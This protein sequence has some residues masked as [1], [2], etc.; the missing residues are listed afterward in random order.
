MH[1]TEEPWIMLLRVLIA[2]G[3]GAALGAERGIRGRAAGLRTHFLV[4]A[5]SALFMI[6]STHIGTFGPEVLAGFTRVTDPG[7]IAAQI[8]TGIGF[9]GAGAIIKEGF[10]VR[11]LTTAA[12]LWVSA[13]IGMA[14]GAGFYILAVGTTILALF[15]L[16]GIS[17]LERGIRRSIYRDLI[18]TSP[19]DVDLSGI[20]ESVSMPGVRVMGLDLTQDY[21]EETTTARLSL[22][23]SN[24]E[25]VGE[26]PRKLLEHVRDAGIPL[27]KA[28]WRRM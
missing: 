1:M 20:V 7:R 4:G 23:L 5:G 2:A 21:E 11:G 8:V 14:S 24:R 27:R 3:L 13:A 28:K 12:S 19:L 10:T 25:T 9:L 26:L 22:R 17:R 6:M 18:L 16:V 15:A